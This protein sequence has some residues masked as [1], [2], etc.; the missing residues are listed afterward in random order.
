MP[1]SVDERVLAVPESKTE[2][3]L[4]DLARSTAD[5]EDDAAEEAQRQRV[6]RRAAAVERITRWRRQATLLIAS[7]HATSPRPIV[8][9]AQDEPATRRSR[10][11]LAGDRQHRASPSDAPSWATR[12]ARAV[13]ERAVPRDGVAAA[14]EH[15]QPRAPAL[16]AARPTARS[17]SRRRAGAC[18]GRAFAG[19][20]RPLR[21]KPRG[22]ASR[23]R[24]APDG[25]DR[26][27]QPGAEQ[28]RARRHRPAS[29]ISEYTRT[30]TLE[31]PPP[32][33][34]KTTPKTRPWCAW[35]TAPPQP[36]A[37]ARRVCARQ[38]APPTSRTSI[39]ACERK[40]RACASAARHYADQAMRARRRRGDTKIGDNL[41][42]A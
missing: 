35:S 3:A 5:R 34:P 36:R 31:L 27:K 11:E 17:S 21:R 41:P 10:A 18:G 6:G 4:A 26:E 20:R 16:R 25:G 40:E 33:T 32:A 28:R 37:R 9:G 39:A 23:T 42:A 1:T 22:A 14:R 19:A 30:S 24:V 29:S 8:D 7:A 13:R 2:I 15:R 38:A 12:R